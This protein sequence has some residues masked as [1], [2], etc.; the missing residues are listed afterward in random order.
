VE[1]GGLR[2]AYHGWK[3]DAQGNCV[4]R[5]FEPAS[6]KQICHGGYQVERLAGLYWAYLGPK[7]AP[8]LPRWDIMTR[9]DGPLTIHIM[10][11]VACNWLQI[12][13]NSV[14]STHTYYLHGLM[15][16]KHGLPHI[17]AYY[18][19][20][21]EDC[22]FEVTREA[23]WAG[24]RKIR[25]YGDERERG[26]PLIFPCI[27]LVPAEGHIYMHFRVP[28]D[29][30]NTRILRL[31][32]TPGGDVSGMDWD[33]PKIIIEP[34][35]KNADGEY[36]MNTFAS[37]DAMAWETQGAILDRSQEMLG[38]SDRGVA[39]YRRMLREEIEA[40]REGRD[41]A[42]VLRDAA[43][44]ESIVIALSEGQVK[45]AP[46]MNRARRAGE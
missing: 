29:D 33:S 11:D 21:F 20:P 16:I 10:P 34:P 25:V 18:A 19:K 39:L 36:V 31:R 4:E 22:E 7:P 9:R 8:L 17:G 37:Q 43:L 12:M 26:H 3:F 24:V 27:L 41:P 38:A 14:D 15:M 42:G 40:V 28:I 30:E 13:E 35:Y 45:K 23:T 44:N 2:C 6:T 46:E 32:F 1:E 5:P